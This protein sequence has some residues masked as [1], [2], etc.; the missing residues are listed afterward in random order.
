MSHCEH[1]VS[2]AAAVSTDS[3]CGP[4]PVVQ[5]DCCE[6]PQR[7]DYLFWISLITVAIAY[8]IGALMQ[9]DH[10]SIVGVFTGGIFELFNRMWWGILVGVVFVGIL[11]RVPRD[12]VMGLL[13]RDGG[14]GGLLRAILAGVFL[15]LC[16]HGILAVGM[17]LYERG[18]SA[19]QVMAFLLASPWNSF[20]L[21]LI[22]FGLIGVGWTLLFILLSMVIGVVTG[23]I[24]DL[25][26]RR[27]Q[28]PAN[29]WQEKLGER[30]PLGVL[31]REFRQT[32]RFSLSGT[33]GILREGFAGSRV[34]IRWSLFGLVLAGLIRALVPED[35][36]ATWFGATMGGLWLT[37]LATTVIEVCS[38][39][40]TPIAAD[41][42]NRAGAAGNS[43]T[44]LMAGVATDY[45][46]IMSIRDT[47]R[48]WRVALFLPLITVPQI[49]LIGAVLNQF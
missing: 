39:G 28:L 41:L 23:A 38:E 12:L 22:L 26:V 2:K 34:V 16:S 29:P 42:M 36:F 44:F 48:S 10:V 43:F 14:I 18:A 40:S 1:E 45:T 35:A 3:C 37:L 47:T 24:F 8:P 25:L 27:G 15:D 4:E 30:Q 21:T 46:E 33:A 49:I 19:G 9:H 31:L 17:K 5:D 13:G 11:G 6:T 20:S 32:V 7:R